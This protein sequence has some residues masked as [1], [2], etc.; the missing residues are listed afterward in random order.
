MLKHCS[1]PLGDYQWML[2]YRQNTECN[3]LELPQ[4]VCVCSLKIL[5][6]KHRHWSGTA[7]ILSASLH[8]TAVLLFLKTLCNLNRHAPLANHCF[9][10]WG[11]YVNANIMCNSHNSWLCP[12]RAVMR[13][14]LTLLHFII[15]RLAG[16]LRSDS[17]SCCQGLDYDGST[18]EI[19]GKSNSGEMVK[20]SGE[21]QLFYPPITPRS[22]ILLK[23]HYAKVSYVIC[24]IGHISHGF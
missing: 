22:S 6:R 19:S 10:C 13:R 21:V 4:T 15:L 14:S 18:D 8:Q 2:W 16:V 1:Q 12:Y 17:K 24:G 23:Y 5:E 3:R 9:S 20:H 11:W 7:V